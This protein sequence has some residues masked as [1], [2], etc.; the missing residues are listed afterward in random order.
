[1]RTENRCLS[2]PHEGN[3]LP[4]ERF[5]H[6]HEWKAGPW[7]HIGILGIWKNSLALR[8]AI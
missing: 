2:R 3:S 1:M 5:N 8:G 6:N 4:F 7:N